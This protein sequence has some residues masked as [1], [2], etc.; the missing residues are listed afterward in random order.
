M[1]DLSGIDHKT[2]VERAKAIILKPRDEWPRIEAETTSSADIFTRYVIPLSLIGPVS[3]FIGGQVFGYGALGFSYRPGLFGA[4][5][6][7]VATFLLNIGILTLIADFLAPKFGGAAGRGNA[8]KLVAYGSTAWMLAGIFGLIPS[9]GFFGLLGLYSFYLYYVG[10]GPLMKLPQDKALGFTAVTFACAIALYLVIGLISGTVAGAFGGGVVAGDSD[11][12]GTITLP[13]GG[14]IDVG[15]A[16]EFGKRMED[17][18]SGKV[19][20]VDTAKMQALLPASIGSYQR[21]AVE[22]TGMGAMGSQAEG[23]YTA[24]D[25]SF[26][27]KIIDMSAMGALAGMGVAMGVEHSREDA[28]GYERTG[29]VDGQMQS[30]AWRKSDQH[31]KFGVVVANRFMI[32]AEGTA[33]SIDELKAAVATIDQG[34][35]LSLAG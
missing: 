19:Q 7:A 35:L 33:G 17:V 10:A 20:P 14:S 13:G 26:Q 18:A 2:I 34:N 5:T 6:T 9:L 22:S 11:R 27:L 21:T 16:E 4:L 12:G 24:G 8:F 3:S 1:V 32:E 30:E 25:N 15:K 28:N 31:G 23:T 29:T